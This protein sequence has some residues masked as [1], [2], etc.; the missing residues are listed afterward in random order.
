[1]SLEVFNLRGQ[2]VR[3]YRPGTMNPGNHKV[4]FDGMDDNGSPLASGVYFYRLKAGAFSQSRKM[5]LMK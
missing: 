4:I 5:I 3:S 2:K 1:V